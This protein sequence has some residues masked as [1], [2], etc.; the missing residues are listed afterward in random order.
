[1][2]FKLLFGLLWSVLLTVMGIQSASA[3]E[4]DPSSTD[5]ISA[6]GI[7]D[8]LPPAYK[9]RGVVRDGES[10][11]DESFE[12][13]AITTTPISS[14]VAD[15]ASH[16]LK[17]VAIRVYCIAPVNSHCVVPVLAK[18]GQPLIDD[19]V[20][21]G[22][23]AATVPFSEPLPVDTSD[24]FALQGSAS[25]GNPGSNTGRVVYQLM[26]GRSFQRVAGD[27]YAN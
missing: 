21:P 11:T 12:T 10:R 27:S 1:M 15:K 24:G 5:G 7:F 6:E 9:I 14:L 16:A 20:L 23:G 3:Q 2:R 22:G 26:T 19:M 18:N 4:Y 25:L 8:K 13:T 17:A